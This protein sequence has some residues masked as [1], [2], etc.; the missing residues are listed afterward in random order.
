M[1]YTNMKRERER[2][3]GID[4]YNRQ[5]EPIPFRIKRKVT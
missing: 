4:T 3:R 1:N 2:E 5:T